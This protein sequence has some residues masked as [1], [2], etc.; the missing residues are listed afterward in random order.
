[1]LYYYVINCNNKVALK[2]TN[3]KKP[4]SKKSILDYL[5]F[6]KKKKILNYTAYVYYQSFNFLYLQN[7]YK[8]RLKEKNFNAT[9]ILPKKLIKSILFK[10]RFISYKNFNIKYFNEV[11]YLFVTNI[12]LNKI[13]YTS[14]QNSKHLSQFI[15]SDLL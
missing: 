12:F 1:M 5:Y 10:T 8:I 2:Y 11:V 7:I 9:Y 15:F 6:I 13:Q 3:N 4:I 14:L